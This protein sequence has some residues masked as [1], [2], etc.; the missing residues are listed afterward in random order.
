MEKEIGPPQNNSQSALLLREIPQH[1]DQ[2][3]W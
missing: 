2:G 1:L 3:V